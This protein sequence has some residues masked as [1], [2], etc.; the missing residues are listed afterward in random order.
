[1]TEDDF[2]LTPRISHPTLLLPSKRIITLFPL[3]EVSFFPYAVSSQPQFANC[4]CN[5]CFFF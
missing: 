4:H 3:K 2:H 5:Y 1:M